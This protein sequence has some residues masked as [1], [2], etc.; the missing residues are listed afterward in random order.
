ME[1]DTTTERLVSAALLRLRMRTPFF[2]TLALFALIRVSTEHP[3]AATDGRDVFINP[4]FFQSLDPAQQ[5]AILLH[6]VLHAAL[7]HVSRRGVR[8]EMVWNIAADIVV[9]GIIA[10]QGNLDIPPDTARDPELAKLSVEE[11]YELL[12][13]PGAAA[14]LARARSVQQ[15][16][17][18]Q[19]RR[20]QRH[21]GQRGR[22]HCQRSGSGAGSSLAQCFPASERCCLGHPEWLA[23]R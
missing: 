16:S 18:W 23:P 4:T 10:E 20:S 17:R 11:V 3:T 19:R 7:L 8:D 5:D 12:L 2:A 21:G 13:Q 22:Q 14:A 6:A 15:H 9:N 1:L